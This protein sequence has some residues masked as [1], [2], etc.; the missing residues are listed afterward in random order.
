MKQL[1]SIETRRQIPEHQGGFLLDGG[2]HF[3]AGLRYLLAARNLQITELAAFTNLLQKRLAPVDTLHA[4]LRASNGSNGTFNLSFGTEFKSGF[5]IEVV[6]D[7]GAVSVKPTEVLVT[8]K[9]ADGKKNEEP[10]DFEVSSGVVLEVEAFAYSIQTGKANDKCT[11]HQAMMD[12]KIIQRMLESGEHG[13]AVQS[14]L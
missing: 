1:C 11:P 2:V 8:S 13:G 3:I 4:T 6:T 7:R 5:D 10:W 14:M 9:G 12:L